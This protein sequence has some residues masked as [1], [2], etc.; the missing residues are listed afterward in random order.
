MVEL[1]DLIPGFGGMT[2][3]AFCPE[4]AKVLILVCMAV[5]A[6]LGCVPQILQVACVDVAFGAGCFSVNADQFERDLIM[7]E[8]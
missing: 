7:V 6:I 3:T 8:F 2:D 1:S 4:L 5:I